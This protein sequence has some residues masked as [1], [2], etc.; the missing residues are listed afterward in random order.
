MISY[1]AQIIL[2]EA[3]S[4]P[5]SILNKELW[6]NKGGAKEA[7]DQGQVHV[8]RPGQK[9]GAAEQCPEVMQ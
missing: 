4:I 6:N 5:W 1:L 7:G 3:G 2:S 8:C 9:V